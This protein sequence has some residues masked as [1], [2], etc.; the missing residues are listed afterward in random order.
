MHTICGNKRQD[1]VSRLVGAMVTVVIVL[2][3]MGRI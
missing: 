3:R 2:L 1:G